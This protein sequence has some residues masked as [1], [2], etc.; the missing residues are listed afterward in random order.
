MKAQFFVI[1]T[2]IMIYTL[3]NLVQYIYDF[4][5]INLVQL[6]KMSEIYYIPYIKDALNKTVISSN[7]SQ[8]CNKVD[9]DLNSTESSLK[10]VMISRGINLT[11]SHN[12]NC[13]SSRL[14]YVDF[15]FSLITQDLYTL[16]QFRSP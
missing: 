4:S 3:M 12:I 1:S 8:D 11:T 16:T 10:N 6:K 13:P 15:S 7:T 9:L 2:V 14:S 5:D